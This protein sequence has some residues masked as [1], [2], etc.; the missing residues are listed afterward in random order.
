[1]AAC[2]H[3]AMLAA[4]LV[5]VEAHTAGVAP[6]IA[7]PYEYG[8]TSA[9]HRPYASTGLLRIQS[10]SGGS[11]SPVCSDDASCQALCP[12]ADITAAQPSLSDAQVQQQVF[13]LLTHRIHCMLAAPSNDM[14]IALCSVC[15]K[16]ALGVVKVLLMAEHIVLLRFVHMFMSLSIAVMRLQLRSSHHS[17]T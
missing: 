17:V 9:S 5:I 4:A 15:G 10:T 16:H 14:E 6:D 3:V 1:M 12:I 11:S 2:L 13:G 8:G 7:S